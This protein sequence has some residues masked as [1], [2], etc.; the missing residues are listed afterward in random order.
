MN[1]RILTVWSLLVI[2]VI[3]CNFV[4]IVPTEPTPITEIPAETP[5]PAEENE[6]QEPTPTPVPTDTPTPVPT[7]TP[8][9]T[10]YFLQVASLCPP[11]AATDSAGRCCPY[12]Y[13]EVNGMCAYIPPPA[14]PEDAPASTPRH[15]LIIAFIIPLLVIGI[16]WLIVEL[17]VVRYVQPRGID[18]STIRIKA[19]DGL[20]L[21]TTISL[22]ARRTLTLA[23]TRMT[24]PRVRSF[25]EKPLEQELIHEALQYSNLEALELSL[26]EISERFKDL[27]IVHELFDDFGVEVL[28]FN[29]EAQYSQETMDAINRKAE[30][31]AGGTAFLAY[32]AAAHLDPDSP[33][34]RELYRVYQETTGHV[35]AARNLGG[36]LTSLAEVFTPKPKISRVEDVDPDK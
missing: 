5:V 32:A 7:P 14:R 20:F 26:R 17:N 30:A 9:A 6:I 28:R 10:R 35:D 4:Q 31:S 11:N 24:W 23:S 3:A 33:E 12:A 1:K 27:P 8:T 22:T 18:L 16:P 25:V 36:G 15:G 34:A 19:Q 13:S 2:L 21:D 29:I